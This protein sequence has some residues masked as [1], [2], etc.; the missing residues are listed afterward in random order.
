MKKK[1]NLK[2]VLY[3]VYGLGAAGLAL[4]AAGALLKSIPVFVLGFLIMIAG[5][6][7]NLAKW[8]CPHCG[9]HLGR[10]TPKYCPHCGHQVDL[11]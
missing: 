10:D 5:M 2:Q 11:E 4:F 8:R 6:V 3:I 1:L 9:E 7:F